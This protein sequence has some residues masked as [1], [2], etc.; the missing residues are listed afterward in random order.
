MPAPAGLLFYGL[1]IS[2]C[3]PSTAINKEM[4]ENVLNRPSF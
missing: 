2:T 1:R 4:Q 3:R